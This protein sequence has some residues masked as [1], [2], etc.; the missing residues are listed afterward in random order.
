MAEAGRVVAGS[1]R[2]IRLVAPGPGTRPLADRVKEA[3]FGILGPDLDGLRRVLE[4]GWLAPIAA[5]EP[6]DAA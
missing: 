6:A 2:G 3:V 4:S 1:A 5:G